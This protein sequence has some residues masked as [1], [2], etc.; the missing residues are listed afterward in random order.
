[1]NKNLILKTA[2]DV[3]LSI[4]TNSD[5]NQIFNKIDKF[6]P[7]DDNDFLKLS[8]DETDLLKTTQVD[9]NQLKKI[10][11]IIQILR[12]GI[13]ISSFEDLKKLKEKKIE[14]LIDIDETSL[15]KIQK[16][17]ILINDKNEF[18]NNLRNKDDKLIVEQYKLM[19]PTT[20]II[21]IFLGFIFLSIISSYLGF[22]HFSLE[23]KYSFFS[24]TSAFW[25]MLTGG[26][27]FI[28]SIYYLFQN[29][30]IKIK[31]IRD[32]DEIIT[33]LASN[34]FDR[35][36]KKINRTISKLRKK[37]FEI[38]M[39]SIKDASISKLKEFLIEENNL[40]TSLRKNF[41]IR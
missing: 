41:V 34:F 12:S 5:L 24:Q 17:F 36:E 1:M 35:K 19:P 21:S 23:D 11:I 6:K 38:E 39:K 29:I 4:K 9:L 3:D 16:F 28:L 7:T 26:L 22:S 37:Q 8:E 2:S 13:K 27:I 25:T 20:L 32:K 40:L 18:L 31:Q 33:E 30:F 15:S 10:K 14:S